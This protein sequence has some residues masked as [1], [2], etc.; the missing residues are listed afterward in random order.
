MTDQNERKGDWMQTYTGRQF[1]P[2]DPRPEE[3]HIEDIAHA[4]ANIARFGGHSKWFYSV[5]QHSLQVMDLMPPPWKLEGL[6][7]DAAEA[8]IGDMV[9]PLK[10]WMPEF[11]AIEKGIMGAIEERFSLWYPSRCRE[12]LRTADDTALAT[13][14]QQVM[15]AP[16][17]PWGPLPEPLGLLTAA[18]PVEVESYFLGAF[19]A[20]YAERVGASRASLG[21]QDGE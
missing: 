12:W 1:W 11:R 2:L 16:P 15:S 20:L 6:M 14:A 7:H 8:Y 10:Q 5:A 13:E 17:V 9:R 4:L 19:A 3:V 18:A 21:A